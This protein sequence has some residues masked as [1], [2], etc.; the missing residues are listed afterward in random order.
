MQNSNA[1]NSTDRPVMGDNTVMKPADFRAVQLE[2]NTYRNLTNEE[3]I[4]AYADDFIVNR[5]TVVVVSSA[6]GDDSVLAEMVWDTAGGSEGALET[7]PY[8]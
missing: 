5:Q 4:R 6:I 3:C 1:L 7:P 8:Q 2:L